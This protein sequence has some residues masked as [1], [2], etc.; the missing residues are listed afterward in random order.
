MHHTL[1][2]NIFSKYLTF[3]V[4]FYN[5]ISWLLIK[6]DFFF[7]TTRKLFSLKSL[8]VQDFEQFALKGRHLGKKHLGG[9]IIVVM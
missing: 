1:F 4:K 6:E 8:Q 3:K 2:I 5:R 7:A 9:I